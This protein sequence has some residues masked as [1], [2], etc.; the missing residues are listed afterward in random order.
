MCVKALPPPATTTTMARDSIFD[1]D[2][3]RFT[4][5]P[6]K[7]RSI[8]D[9]YEK[10]AASFWLPAEVDLSADP[11]DWAKLDDDERHF[12]KQTL[13][14]FAASD[15]V[16]NENLALRFLREVKCPEA[17]CFYAFQAMIEN[18]H[19]HMY[20]LLIDT[21]V[22]DPGE[23][24]AL[25]N[26]V[27]TFPSV[28]KKADWALRWIAS[29]DASFAE[30]LV[31]FA[32]VEGIFF[33]GSFCS[34]FWLKKRGLMPGLCFSN[35]LIARDEG[36]HTDFACHLFR[37]YVDDKPSAERIREIVREAVD[38]E[39]GFTAESLPVSLIG[40]NCATMCEYIEFVADRLL[41]E[42]GAPKLYGT[43]NPFDFMK[44]IGMEGKTSFF[45]K[46]VAE[47]RMSSS[48]GD[49]TF[50]LNEEF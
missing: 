4:L 36:L 1:N 38:I 9:F 44:T 18:V 26:A 15:G 35:E 41:T 13:A 14:F 50:K 24:A 17:R 45:E 31:A 8:F 2:V 6:I 32:C 30:R 33:S 46:R 37:D 7:H 49:K 5:F 43:D 19:G 22:R 34:I 10:S 20:S 28:K 21:Y 27:T 47:Y 25:F 48:T 16:V 11:R 39:H 23:K 12:I 3:S 40:M 42:L 29:E